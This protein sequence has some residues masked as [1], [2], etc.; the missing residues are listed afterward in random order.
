MQAQIML[1]VSK[2]LSIGLCLSK[3]IIDIL[4]WVSFRVLLIIV[5]TTPPMKIVCFLYCSPLPRRRIICYF[6][7]SNE[8]DVETLAE[9]VVHMDSLYRD[10]KHINYFKSKINIL[11]TGREEDVILELCRPGEKVSILLHC[12]V[13]DEIFHMY[14]TV[15]EDFGVM[16]PFNPF[17]VDVLKELT[18]A[19]SQLQPNN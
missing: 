3:G 13:N 14:S 19:P 9:D 11:F 6:V 1:S 2:E 16:F 10:V 7:S 15:F 4:C 18:L 17:E 8:S 5:V 12:G